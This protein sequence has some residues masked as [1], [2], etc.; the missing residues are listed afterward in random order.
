MKIHKKTNA[1]R[2]DFGATFA[3]VGTLWNLFRFYVGRVGRMTAYKSRL[4][5]GTLRKETLLQS[6]LSHAVGHT[7]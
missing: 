7:F 1:P 2:H 3:S 5:V 4:P 6:F